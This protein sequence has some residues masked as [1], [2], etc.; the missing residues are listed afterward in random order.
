MES[1]EQ[2]DSTSPVY[3]ERLRASM[4]EEAQTLQLVGRRHVRSNN[5]W[6]HNS[7]R[8]MKGRDRC[9]ALLNP[10]D[11]A[12]A[13]VAQG[14]QVTLRS[15][16]GEITLSAEL[17]DDIMPGVVSVPHGFGH[18][19][20]GVQLRV[21]SEYAGV[22]VNDLT[23]ELLLDTLTGNAVLNGVPVEL[24]LAGDAKGESAAS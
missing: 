24:S 19:R 1:F 18:A 17:T 10:V 11:A 3:L 9:T 14:A 23:D 15:R 16:T 4:G 22:S 12:R 2:A 6:L 21:A 13:G 20:D 7:E 5:S 8:L